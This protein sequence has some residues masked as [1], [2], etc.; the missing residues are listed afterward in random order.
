M[1][2]SLDRAGG[3]RREFPE[4]LADSIASGSEGPGFADLNGLAVSWT[5]TLL[6]CPTCGCALGASWVVLSGV[7]SKVL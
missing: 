5:V 4:V 1:T 3:C 2:G 7:R 6:A